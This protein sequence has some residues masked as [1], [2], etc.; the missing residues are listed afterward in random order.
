MDAG[1]IERIETNM[2]RAAAALFA[3]AVGFACYKLL[4]LHLGEPQLVGCTAGA[5]AL[6]YLPCSRAFS[7]A[8]AHGSRFALP[9][10][11][12]AEFEFTDDEL[13]LTTTDRLIPSGEL[14]LT[15]A[16]RLDRCEEPLMLDDVLI[17]IDPDARVVR[18]F[19]RGA[20]PTPG[21]LQ[22]KIANHL[23]RA[24]PVE[25]PADASQALSDALAELRRSLR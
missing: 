22:S 13:L 16:D 12:L 4:G 2:E 20:M 25:P 9:P 21:Q 6:A 1:V 11:E 18:L 19:D 5:A 8:G 23:G 10:F 3:A 24:S 7:G 17:G 14:E 15:D